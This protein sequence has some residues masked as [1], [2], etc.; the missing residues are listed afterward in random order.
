MAFKSDLEKLS[1]NVKERI[2]YI[3]NEE[4]TKQ[5]LINPFIQVLGFEIFN[6]LEVRLEYTAD[7]GKKK[8]EKVDYAL[9]K[10][11]E[12]IIFIEAKS[13][14]ENLSNHNAQLARYFNST[15]DVKLG[16]LTNGI[17]YK[18][19]TDLDSNNI[20]DSTPFLVINILELK[21]NDIE[22]LSKLR[23][24]NFDSDGLINYAEELV[25]TN[26]LNK[27]LKDLLK[28]P[29]DEFIRFI[30]KDFSETRVTD[31]VIDRFRP[32]VKKALSNAV[33]DIVSK[34][35]YQEEVLENSEEVASTVASEVTTEE[36]IKREII[37]TENELKFFEMVK[38]YL[39]QAGK[40]VSNLAYK[41]TTN[42][43]SIFNK[44]GNRWFVRIV[45]ESSKP[46]ILFKLE[47]E[48]IKEIT[49]KDNVEK[50]PKGIGN[51][52]IL[53]EGLGDIK[54]YEN[55]IVQAFSEIE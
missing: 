8:G 51:S 10:D 47:I 54:E 11:G 40:D 49:Q 35:L 31:K 39:I 46:S 50:A 48:T 33:L 41:S 3:T 1:L 30:V 19:F 34:G 18:F 45:L 13:L 21:E 42:Y 53:I 43:F 9:F 16:I 38:E 44:T 15:Q 28:N 36:K 24:D 2:E 55:V 23:K 14:T 4:M 26:T 37:T 20:M 12:P 32:L 27:S 5:S 17:E 22:N 25:Y 7:F 29:S 6:P 52:R